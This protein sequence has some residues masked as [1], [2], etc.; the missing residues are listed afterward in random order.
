MR[1]SELDHHV[2]P[3]VDGEEAGPERADVEAHLQACP[4]CRDRVEAERAAREAVFAGRTALASEAPP[5]LRRRCQRLC[6]GSQRAPRWT[7]WALAAA[8]SLALL[9]WFGRTDAGTP[10]LAAQLTLDH[11]K[12]SRFGSPRVTGSPEQ[13]AVGWQE[14][15]GWPIRVP[16]APDGRTRL[17]GVRR[18][19]SSDGTTAHVMYTREGRPVSLF[20]ARD[21]GRRPRV[22]DVF[23]HEAVIWSA[24]D[25]TYVLVGRESR[26]DMEALAA[27]IKQQEEGPTP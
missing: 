23:G 16:A 5:E 13:L 14:R 8:A 26:A 17:S 18:C 9:F 1:C 25:R 22:L 7:T 10:V 4:P 2:V 6:R 15:H 12:C 27:R 20:I 21:S 19:A 3:F 24:G 11:V